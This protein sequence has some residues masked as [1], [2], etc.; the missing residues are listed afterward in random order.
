M[1][2]SVRWPTHDSSVGD[3]AKMWFVLSVVLFLISGMFC[4]K[5]CIIVDVQLYILYIRSDRQHGW[6]FD[7]FEKPPL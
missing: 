1:L 5:L 6:T 4:Y 2:P 7:Q 3:V